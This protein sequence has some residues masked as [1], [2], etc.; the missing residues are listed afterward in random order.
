MHE[1]AKVLDT[2]VQITGY[3]TAQL[4]AQYCTHAFSI[5]IVRDEA[6][7]IRWDRSGMIVTEAFMYSKSHHLADFFHHFSLA[8][9]D[10]CGKDTTV[11]LP[12]P[13]AASAAQKAFR[14]DSAASLLC[15]KISNQ[16]FIVEAPVTT[17]YTPPGHATRGSRAWDVANKR[18]AYMKD[19]WRIDMDDFDAEG[20]TYNKLMKSG[21]KNI[22][23]CLASGDVADPEYHVTKTHLY[24]ARPLSRWA[25]PPVAHLIPH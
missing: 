8:S 17:A 5:L 3:S 7:I 4:G 20:V 24:S 1:T 10:M 11:S 21:V 14:L 23:Q 12:S 25:C 19:T 16:L 6:Q 15:L 18:L 2:L 13:G 22:A 9:L